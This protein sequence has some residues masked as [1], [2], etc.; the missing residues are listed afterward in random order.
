[1]TGDAGQ[2]RLESL[3]LTYLESGAAET[4]D[5]VALFVLI[6]LSR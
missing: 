2:S 6:G 4:V 1:L 3:T 5:A